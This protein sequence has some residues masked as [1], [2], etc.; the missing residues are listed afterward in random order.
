[1][2]EQ[3][4]TPEIVILAGALACA[5]AV[6]T[7]VFSQNHDRNQDLRKAREESRKAVGMANPSTNAELVRRA[8]RKMRESVEIYR[9][10]TRITDRRY[11]APTPGPAGYASIP[12]NTRL[13]WKNCL[14]LYEKEL[15]TYMRDTSHLQFVDVEG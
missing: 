6:L 14:P 11:R 10:I 8:R 3:L 4:L 1:M 2:F 12:F 15:D 13:Y 5:L 9:R 7:L